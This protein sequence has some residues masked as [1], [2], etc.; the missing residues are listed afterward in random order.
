M[1]V[2]E[3]TKVATKKPAPY[4]EPMLQLIP[5]K[6]SVATIAVTTSPALLY[7]N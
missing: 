2:I 1:M 7:I 5:S 3:T 4:R 6:V